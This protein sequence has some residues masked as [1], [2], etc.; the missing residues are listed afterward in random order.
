MNAR[1]A[2]RLAWSL[3]VACLVLIALALLLDFLLTDDILSYPWQIRINHRILYPIYTVLTGMLALVY[4]TIGALIA[5]RL[6]RNPIGWIFCG[7]GL[8]YGIRRF[9]EA[10]SEYTLYG[11]VALPLGEYAG[12][13]SSLV[14]FTG[15]A[16]AVVFL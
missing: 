4:P 12:W 9:T 1:T 16:L 3:W 6:P 15:Q 5:S 13:I 2:T 10:Y 8:L 14:E 7:V 11:N